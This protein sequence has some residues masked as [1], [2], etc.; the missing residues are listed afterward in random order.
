VEQPIALASA[1]ARLVPVRLQAPL[2]GPPESGHAERD[3]SEKHDEHHD[4]EKHE[5]SHDAHERGALEPG[6]HKIE[7]VVRD[8][9]DD[10]V[11]RHEKSSFIVP[12]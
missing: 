7:F 4:G 12:H 3:R 11:T 1:T 6:T 5:E 2:E 10:R 9:D 8:I